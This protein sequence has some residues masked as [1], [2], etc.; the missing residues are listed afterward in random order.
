MIDVD[1][2]DLEIVDKRGMPASILGSV[3]HNSIQL[4]NREIVPLKSAYK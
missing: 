2:S 1:Q 4:N 3:T